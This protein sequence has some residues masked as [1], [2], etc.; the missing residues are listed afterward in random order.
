MGPALFIMQRQR[1]VFLDRDGVI[2]EDSDSYIRSAG[3]WLP[4]PGSVEGIAGLTH[5]GFRVAVI[6]NQSGLARGFFDLRALNAMHRKLRDL[7]SLKGG[8]VEMIAFC[9][10]APGASCRCRKPEPGLVIQVAQRARVALQGLPF[11]GDSLADIQVAKALGMQPIL[12]KTGKGRRT[13]A[14]GGVELD[15][16][17]V[18]DDLRAVSE[19][20]IRRWGNS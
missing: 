8:R 17:L 2:N 4:I 16:I 13:L 5:A 20:L 1:F 10:H 9:P 18:F 6:S 11:V 7:L 3:E 14:V 12:V 19:A 15:D